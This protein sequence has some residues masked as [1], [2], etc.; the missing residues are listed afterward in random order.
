MSASTLTMVGSPNR[1]L[2]RILRGTAG[3]GSGLALVGLGTLLAGGHSGAVSAELIWVFALMAV[4]FS[5]VTWL[6]APRQ[7]GNKVVW[8]MTA[9]AFFGGVWIAGLVGAAPLA[10]DP[11]LV[12]IGGNA[13]VPSVL[14]RPA[15]VIMMLTYPAVLLAMF[16]PLTFGLLLFPDGR[17]PSP[18]WRWVGWLAGV[19]LAVLT[20]GFAWGFR[21]ESTQPADAAAVVENGFLVIGLAIVLS[22]T[23][24]V[25]RYRRSSGTTRQQFKW[26]VWGASIFVPTQIVAFTLGG[27]RYED[28][29][30]LPFVIGTVAFLGSYAIAVGKYRLFDIDVVINKTVMVAVLGV[31]I[32]TLYVGMVVGVGSLLGDGT[33]VGM[34]VAATVVVA[35]AFGPVRRQAQRWA[36]RA[37]YG[38]RATPYEV[39][40]RF[41]HRAAQAG[42]E[43]LLARLPKLIVDGTGAIKAT[44]WLR[45]D[46]GFRPAASWP[47]DTP[48]SPIRSA[49]T[50]GDPNAD[51]SVPVFHGSELLGGISLIQARGEPLRDGAQRLL[52]DLAAGMGLAL[53]NAGLTSR[54]QEQVSELEA[55]RERILAAADQARRALEQDL[56]SGPQQ[57][58]VALKV[59]LGPIRKQAAQAGAAKTAGLLAGLETDAGE[60][61]R[62]VREFSGGV[63]PPLLEAEGLTTAIL[64]RCQNSPVPI[65]VEAEGLGRYSRDVEAAVYFTILEALQNIAKYAAASTVSV[66]LEEAG[67]ELMFEVADDGRGFD[68]AAVAA[69]SGLENMADRLDAIAGRLNLES[70]PGAGTIVRGTVPV[71]VGAPV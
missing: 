6:V 28:L 47:E 14:P 29:V 38:K 59:M 43:E 22:F 16:L 21:P 61:I 9:S 66:T 7:P 34:Q 20:V 37:V 39:L 71:S 62:A 2:V 8:T 41:S 40:A 33:R 67:G 58:L 17:L 26:V 56:D 55:S 3:L 1:A 27:T 45:S 65:G 19:S 53:R 51:Y 35:L 4:F 24:L 12:L 44:L 15:A 23:G 50:F 52:T 32:T 48:Q 70:S 30:V 5:V 13:V 63:Y 64:Q 69:G 42:D 11:T 49:E 54:L 36:N 68:P 25:V 57:Q 31:V 46:G 18:R 60:A 10:D